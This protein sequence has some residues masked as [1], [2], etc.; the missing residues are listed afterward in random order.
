M[1][2]ESV[3]TEALKLEP[4]ERAAVAESLLL[5]LPE[6]HKETGGAEP[7]KGLASV[8]AKPPVFLGSDAMPAR[9]RQGIPLRVSGE[10]YRNGGLRP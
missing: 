3:A 8:F 2:W 6:P 9:R 4:R 10:F 5:S 7:G 1:T